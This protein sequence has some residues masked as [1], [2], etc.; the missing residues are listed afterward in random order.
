MLTKIFSCCHLIPEIQVDLV[1]I[2]SKYKRKIMF[3]D[4]KKTIK[5]QVFER[6]VHS[7]SGFLS[8]SK[9]YHHPYFPLT[10]SLSSHTIIIDLTF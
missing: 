2:G 4:K 3:I 5:F 8:K 6:L 7:H 1:G 10:Y 9:V